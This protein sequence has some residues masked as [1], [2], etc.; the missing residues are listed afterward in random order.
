MLSISA[1]NT[2]M[3]FLQLN[4]M[5][6]AAYP[7]E[8]VVNMARD[9]APAV[10]LGEH[11]DHRTIIVVLCMCYAFLLALAQG[12]LFSSRLALILESLT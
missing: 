10:T 2:A 5:F 1:I 9:D 6:V 4:N 11:A 3:V 8:K 7:V 12:M